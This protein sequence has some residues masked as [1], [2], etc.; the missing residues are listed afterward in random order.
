MYDFFFKERYSELHVQLDLVF[1]IR[2]SV[3]GNNFNLLH[4]DIRRNT[5][6]IFSI[7]ATYVIA[8]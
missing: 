6:P 8:V 1:L 5:Y 7:L 4:F 2:T 3:L